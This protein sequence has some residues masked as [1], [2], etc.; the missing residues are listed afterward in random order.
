M[1]EGG[2]IIS[3]LFHVFGLVWMQSEVSGC[4]LNIQTWVLQVNSGM[5]VSFQVC[6]NTTCTNHRK[7]SVYRSVKGHAFIH[8]Q[9]IYSFTHVLMY[10]ITIN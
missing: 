9:I 4:E 10:S 3:D 1:Y 8:S 5:N 7:Q 2:L 6:G